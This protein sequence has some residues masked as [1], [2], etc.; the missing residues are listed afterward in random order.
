MFKVKPFF[1]SLGVVKY[2]NGL[3]VGDFALTKVDNRA[4]EKEQNKLWLGRVLK[5]SGTVKKT[6]HITWMEVSENGTLRNADYKAD[7]VPL[8]NIV[9]RFKF[10]EGQRMSSDLQT[11][12]EKLQKGS[13]NQKD[14]ESS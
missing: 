8:T 6:Y 2:P 1:I 14:S 13:V 5:V 10:V 12:L 3:K 9:A 7:P 4:D 11:E